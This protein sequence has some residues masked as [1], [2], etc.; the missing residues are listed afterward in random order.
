MEQLQH[1]EEF[2]RTMA[3]EAGKPIRTARTEVSGAVFTFKIAAERS[4]RRAQRT[5][6]MKQWLRVQ[7]QWLRVQD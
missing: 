6:Y 2:V 7:E 5:G 4:P 3:V 1:G